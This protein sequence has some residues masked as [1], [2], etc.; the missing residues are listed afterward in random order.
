MIREF[1]RFGFMHIY[2]NNIVINYQQLELQKWLQYKFKEIDKTWSSLLGLS[3]QTK[4]N[5]IEQK[6]ARNA[7]K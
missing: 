5:K 3:S 4:Q 7:P 1:S 2:L 6:Q